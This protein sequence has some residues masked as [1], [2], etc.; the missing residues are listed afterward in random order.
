MDFSIFFYIYVNVY[1]S[2]LLIMNVKK[3]KKIDLIHGRQLQFLGT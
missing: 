1:P 2:E 3:P